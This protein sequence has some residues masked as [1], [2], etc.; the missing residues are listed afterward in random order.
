M[1]MA[2]SNRIEALGYVISARAANDELLAGFVCVAAR[3]R[4]CRP[5][6]DMH[7][8]RSIRNPPGKAP[9]EATE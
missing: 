6:Q 4:K 5:S 8:H 1:A 3:D 7:P 9:H 2:E